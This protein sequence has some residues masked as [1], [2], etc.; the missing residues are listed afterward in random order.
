[1]GRFAG[2]SA[3]TSL[4]SRRNW[5]IGTNPFWVDL[6]PLL[7]SALLPEEWPGLKAASLSLIQGWLPASE[8]RGEGVFL[9]LDEK[10]VW[11]WE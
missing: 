3:E 7:T 8:I 11:D 5:A 4:R 2:L 10:A 6:S 1:M 9:Q